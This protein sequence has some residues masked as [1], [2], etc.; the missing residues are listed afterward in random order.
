MEPKTIILSSGKCSWGKCAFCGW[1]RLYSESNL[2]ELRER[3]RRELVM[4]TD[5]VKIFASGSFLDDQ[6]FPP[7]FRRWVTDQCQQAGVKEL[8]VESRPE[9][10]TAERLADF[11]GF[12]LTVA[13]GLETADPE[14]LKRLNKGFTLSDVESA[15]K[16]LRQN[17]CGV[18]FY[19]LVNPPLVDDIQKEIDLS[20]E[21]ALRLADSVVLINTFP[22][23]LAP[24]FDM[25]VEGKW[26]PLDKEEFESAIEKWHDNPKIEIDFSNW[27]FIPKIP[28]ERQVILK[29]VGEPFLTHPYYEIWQDYIIRFYEPPQGKDIL[30]FLPCAFQKPY[31]QSKLHRRILQTLHTLPNS[32]RLH[33]VMVSSPGL[34]PREFERYYPFA[35]YD[36]PEWEETPEIKA[37]YTQ[38]TAQRIEKFLRRHYSHYKKLIYYLK[39]DSES[40]QALVQACKTLGIEPVACV[41]PD[42]YERF[43]ETLKKNPLAEQVFLAQLDKTI[44]QTSSLL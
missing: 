15:V 19:L 36:W 22:H 33:Q 26:K 6:Q 42:T 23:A 7:E 21:Y 35:H 27:A 40:A 20:A 10:I 18:R 43:K 2:G 5:T 4:G 31:S 28:R 13:I 17:K 25:W 14:L 37:R 39:P 29:G 24:I 30:L 16:I 41:D 9:F 12:K 11:T 3:V 1:G 34:I 38:V 8:I 32:G 44:R